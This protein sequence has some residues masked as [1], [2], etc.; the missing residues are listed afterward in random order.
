[1]NTQNAT[2]TLINKYTIYKNKLLG[3]GSFSKVYLGEIKSNNIKIAIKIINNSDLIKSELDILNIIKNNPH[4]NIISCIDIVTNI[5]NTNI[6]FEYCDSGDLRELLKKPIKEDYVKFY[7]LQLASA[8]KHLH[9]LK[10]QHGD[11]KPRNILLTN[12]KKILKLADFGFSS[13]NKPPDILCGSPLYMAPEM[14][15]NNS[16][17]KQTDLWSIGIIMFEMLFSFHP[18]SKCANLDELKEAI[19]KTNLIIPPINTKNT[20]ISDECTDLLKM[21]LQKSCNK[22]I[23][24]DSFFD[25]I[26]LF[27]FEENNTSNIIN[28]GT[29]DL[30]IR[31]SSIGHIGLPPPPVL[32]NKSEYIDK[33]I[34]IIDNYYDTLSEDVFTLE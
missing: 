12:K 19:S 20:N 23:T 16:Y 34:K 22:R 27:G 30:H 14:L 13:I 6:I 32:N 26:W 9:I 3:A 5:N 28:S 8:L 1:M 2:Q 21:L 25:H 10:I 15:T 31:G 24:W 29:P 17:N 33:N 18:F 7:F 4:Q 11:I